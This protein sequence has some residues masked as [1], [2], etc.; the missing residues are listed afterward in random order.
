MATPLPAIPSVNQYRPDF[1][2]LLSKIQDYRLQ[3]E[4]QQFLE[5]SRAI[6]LVGHQ[7]TGQGLKDGRTRTLENHRLFLSMTQDSQLHFASQFFELSLGNNH[8]PIVMAY[9]FLM[10]TIGQ[11]IR[12]TRTGLYN[13]QQHGNWLQWWWVQRD[14][15]DVNLNLGPAAE[16]SVL[17]HVFQYQRMSR[18]PPPPQELPPIRNLERWQDTQER[19]HGEG[20]E[21]R[22][23]DRSHQ[24]ENRSG[25]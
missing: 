5:V 24:G 18:R 13:S 19:Q 17:R 15:S 11:Y 21:E 14:N 12:T 7:L 3:S 23:H 8:F 16:M 4:A 25:H 2:L 20:N 9:A 22:R 10:P 1:D 6:H